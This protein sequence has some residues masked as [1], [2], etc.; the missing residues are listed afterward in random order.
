L[1]LQSNI[2]MPDAN[3]SF[4]G[5]TIDLRQHPEAY[6]RYVELAGNKLKDPA[7]GMGAK[8]L[9]NAIVSGNHP[10]SAVYR[11]MSDGPDGGKDLYIQSTINRYRNLARTQ[12]LKE[13][14][15]IAGQVQTKQE[16]Q[17]SLRMPVMSGGPTI[18]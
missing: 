6:E 15:E 13:Y 2:E 8:D 14:P 11:L 17:R 16:D 9:L 12:L 18:Q 3:T 1:R 4:N 5:A 7:W 10:L